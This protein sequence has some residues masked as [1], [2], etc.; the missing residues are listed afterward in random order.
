MKAL[1]KLILPL[2][3]EVVGWQIAN[4]LKIEF[5]VI[6]FPKC[7]TT[8]IHKTLVP[9][10]SVYMPD[11]EVQVP[12]LTKGWLKQPA[13]TVK[14]G[15]KNPN[16]IYEPHNVLALLK[17]NRNMKFIVSMRNPADWLFSFYQYRML[18]IRKDKD[19]LKP[20]L[21]KHPAY[22]NIT[23][24]DVVEGGKDFFGL[25]KKSGFFVDYL[26]ELLNWVAPEQIL[27]LMME[28]IADNPIEAYERIFQ[29]L[30]IDKGISAESG[31]EANKNNML[32]DNKAEFNNLLEF[33]A[34]YYKPKN[35]ELHDL[36]LTKWNYDNVYWQ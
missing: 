20:V 9:V 4:K 21:A 29:F 2:R 27:I 33:L 6:G 35:E 28:E 34:E 10:S 17:S 22:R 36:L 12:S 30:G 5:A 26:K 32:Y 19:W 3:S 23:F 7:A 18:E 1:A 14:L 8:S 16:L 11:F 31:V 25:S 15:I 24:A 13:D